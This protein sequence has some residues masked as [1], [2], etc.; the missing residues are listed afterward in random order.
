MNDNE[1][2]V[3][4][5][6]TLTR[7]LIELAATRNGGYTRDQLE[8]LG[9]GWPPPRG[10]KRALSGGVISRDLF[11]RFSIMASAV[12]LDPDEYSHFRHAA[13]RPD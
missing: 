3:P 2:P 9:G 5:R 8:V 10:W 4:G 13:C 11:D 6:V 1:T 12:E 7:G